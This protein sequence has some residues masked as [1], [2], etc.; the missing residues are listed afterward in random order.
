VPQQ[1]T[2]TQDGTATYTYDANGNRTDVNGTTYTT[3]TGNQLTN[4]G[5]YTYAYDAEGNLTEKTELATGNVWDYMCRTK[6]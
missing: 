5:V 6:F 2:P 3:D 4:D 1:G